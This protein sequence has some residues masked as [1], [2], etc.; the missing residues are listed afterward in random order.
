L[1]G[2]SKNCTLLPILSFS[3]NNLATLI[4]FLLSSLV[5]HSIVLVWLRENL[6]F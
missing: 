2:R 4:W 1:K 6:H 3:G 5:T